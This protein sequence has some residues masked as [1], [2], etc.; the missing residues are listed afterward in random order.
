MSRVYCW[1]ITIVGSP[2][3]YYAM[4]ETLE[5]AKKRFPRN[6]LPCNEWETEPELVDNPPIPDGYWPIFRFADIPEEQ[7]ADLR[8]RV[9]TRWK[10][11]CIENRIPYTDNWSQEEIDIV[12]DTD[13]SQ[14]NYYDSFGNLTEPRFTCY[15][16]S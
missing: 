6:G 16:P 7:K 5:E 8:E 1:K 4:G 12:C 14:P 3:V 13:G 11:I 10:K 15:K 2:L 9:V